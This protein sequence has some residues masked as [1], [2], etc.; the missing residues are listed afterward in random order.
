MVPTVTQHCVS[1][2][3]SFLRTCANHHLSIYVTLVHGQS[4]SV[5]QFLTAIFDS[6]ASASNDI[7]LDV[8]RSFAPSVLA[9]CANDK[10]DSAIT[11]R[12][13]RNSSII[14]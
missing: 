2:F 14:F 8:R 4:I 7:L 6:A 1:G 5:L 11:V 10:N 12:R 9:G 13:H 3:V